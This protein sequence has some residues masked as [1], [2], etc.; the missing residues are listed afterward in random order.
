MSGEKIYSFAGFKFKTN[1]V[2]F[3]FGFRCYHLENAV[4]KAYNYGNVHI[5]YIL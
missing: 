4:K 3:V 2:K 1:A 5:Y